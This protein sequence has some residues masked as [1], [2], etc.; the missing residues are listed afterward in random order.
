MQRSAG[1][2]NILKLM[3]LVALVAK[4]NSKTRF[5]VQSRLVRRTNLL[6]LSTNQ[7]CGLHNAAW[8]IKVLSHVT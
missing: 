2:L 4:N 5:A 7:E 6:V 3:N 8:K 1:D